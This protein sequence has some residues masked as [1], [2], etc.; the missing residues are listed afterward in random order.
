MSL[1][2][3]IRKATYNAGSQKALAEMIGVSAQNLSGFKRDRPCGYKKRAQIAA[4]AGEDPVRILIEGFADELDE[5]IPH[6]A[7]AR[8]G[9]KA[10]LDAFP[11][12]KTKNKG[13]HESQN[14][15]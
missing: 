4:I 15:K 13:P 12:Q 11:E 14:T 7:A 2:E 8:A 3:L 10:M 6:E 1:K 5:A 9:L